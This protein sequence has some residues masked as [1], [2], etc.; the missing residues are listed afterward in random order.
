ME[1]KP[2]YAEAH[3]NLGFALVHCGRTGEAIAHYQ[4]AL[5]SKPDYPKALNELAWLRATCPDAAFR[6]GAAA[7]ELARRAVRLPGGKSP[8]FLDTLAAAYAEAGMF[9]EAAETVGQAIDLARQQNKVPLVEKLKARLWLYD[10]ADMPYRQPQQPH[11]TR[12]T[13]PEVP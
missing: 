6:D 1:T 11:P 7:I 9:S 12:A 10:A 5:Q 3:Y 8:E 2:D 13:S 4:D